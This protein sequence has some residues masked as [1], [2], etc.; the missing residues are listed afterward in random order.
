MHW[1]R[2]WAPPLALARAFLDKGKAFGIYG[3]SF[4]GFFPGREAEMREVLS[5]AAFI[6]TRDNE[7]LAFLRREGVRPAILEFGPDGCFGIDVRDDRRGAAFL[8]EQGLESRRFVAV[9]LRTNT[10]KKKVAPGAAGRGDVLNP[11][12]PSAEDR[13]QDE[14]WADKLR[15]IITAAVRGLDLRVLLAPEV[16]KEIEP[17]RRLLLERLDPEVRARVVHRATFWNVD[18][19]ASVYARAHSLVAMEPHSCIVALA[20]G[21]PALHVASLRHGVKAWMFRDLGLPEWLFDID[22]EP[23]DRVV[24][25]LERVHRQPAQARAKVARAMAFVH[26]RS[27]EMMADVGRVIAAQT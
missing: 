21:T 10:P 23:A 11:A 26:Q 12:E 19:A 9:I 15:E 25:A 22:A 7:S 13:A 24:E 3:Q 2:F 1:N 16:D 27:A 14:R 6:Y 18:E 4:D 20:N 8:R 17:A 5:R